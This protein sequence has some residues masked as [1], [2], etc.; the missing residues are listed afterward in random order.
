M[1]LTN[2][3]YNALMR[4]YEAQQAIDREDCQRRKEEVY[5][6]IP[7]MKALEVQAG[8]LALL[9]FQKMMAE[10]ST[11]V[12][13]G[14]KE[15]IQDIQREKAKLLKEHGFPQDYMQMHYVCPECKDT[16]KV[17]GKKCHCFQM[18]ALKLLYAQSNIDGT[19]QKENFDNFS[20]QY[21]DNRKRLAGIGLTNYE[22]MKNIIR[23]C[24]KYI[25]N[26]GQQKES[27]LFYG[28]TGVGKT[29]LTN[30][31]AKALLDRGYAV[32]YFSSAELFDQVAKV[33]LRREPED[34]GDIEDIVD[35][36]DLL[37]IDDL[38]TELV[39]NFV[40]SELFHIIN[41][42]LLAG[43]GTIISTNLDLKAMRDNY[44]ER[45]TSR[46]INQYTTIPLYG[47]DIRGKK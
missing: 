27:I 7:Q 13:L 36:C 10:K 34:G 15:E 33:K 1:A 3:Q 17:D 40:N 45:I 23:H 12:G 44:T 24:Q 46:I 37:V 31:I 18:K 35:T 47:E 32:L 11:D 5:A 39:N 21:Y 9:R 41:N 4:E 14:F 8:E 6:K 19:L 2:S 30:C 25:E 28:N 38:G 26:F 29:F 22:Y 20:F 16:G 43:K 42:R